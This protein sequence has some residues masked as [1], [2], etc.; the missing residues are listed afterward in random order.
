MELEIL[1]RALRLTES[2]IMLAP[3]EMLRDDHRRSLL[4]CFDKYLGSKK[5]WIN[6]SITRILELMIRA[7]DDIGGMPA[8]QLVV[9]DC[10]QTDILPK[11]LQSL[12]LNWECHQTTGPN[13]KEP[14]PDW[15]NE[16]NYFVILARIL[17]VGCDVFLSVV[18]Q[19][20][21][22]NNRDFN[23]ALGHVLDEAFGNMDAIGEPAKAK[24][25]CMALTKLLETG[26]AFIL[27]KLQDLMGLWTSQIIDLR[28][29]EADPTSEYV[30]PETVAVNSAD[31]TS[32]L[33][34]MPPAGADE[35]LAPEES[36]RSKLMYGDVVHT[37]NL[38]QYVKFQLH[39]AIERLGGSQVFESEWLVNVDEDVTKAFLQ[40]GIM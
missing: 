18:Q 19:W 8:V 5:P 22:S 15:K 12:W 2:Y 16:S 40:L 23:L 21:A 29:S 13:R 31:Q 24:L 17:M 37:V 10:L 34:Y 28:H 7:A 11:M 14:P 39:G 35:Q 20:S 6:D 3:N 25:I 38:G 32:S 26:Q 27:S 36:R 30:N 9:Q 33:V 4:A 1:D